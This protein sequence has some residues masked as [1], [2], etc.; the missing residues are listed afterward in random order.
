MNHQ[1]LARSKE[2]NLPF[3]ANSILLGAIE[4]EEK[5]EKLRNDI[6]LSSS[7]VNKIKKDIKMC[8]K[9]NSNYHNH[10]GKKRVGPR[11]AQPI[12]FVDAEPFFCGSLR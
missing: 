4:E 3:H 10:A 8:T 1:A 5:Q 2:Q 11:E 7:K 6:W 12:C 9:F